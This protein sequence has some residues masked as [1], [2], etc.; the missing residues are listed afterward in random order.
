MATYTKEKLSAS[1]VGRPIKVAATATA[2]TLIHATGTSTTVEDE[3][4]LYANNTTT[5]SVELSIEFGG[6]TSPDDLI[7]VQ[8]PAKSGLVLVVPGLIVLGTGSA[9]NIRAFATTANVINI[10]GFVNRITP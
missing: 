2:G 3:V 5:T 1:T 4:W 9:T 10:T 8:I 7:I 6:V